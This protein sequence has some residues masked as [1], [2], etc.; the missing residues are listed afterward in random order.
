VT[1]LLRA[2]RER[3]AREDGHTLPE[4]L[5]AMGILSIVMT[6]LIAVYVQATNAEL[7][8]N[9]RF[10]AQVDAR[11]ALDRIRRDVHCASGISPAG[12]STGTIVV[13]LPSQCRGGGGNV[14]WCTRSSGQAWTLVRVSGSACNAGTTYARAVTTQN[15]FLFTAQTTQSLAKLRVELP[16]NVDRTKTYKEYRLLDEIVLRNSTR[17]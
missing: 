13:T 12:V 15:V 9:K 4:L 3:V 16:V 10:Q 8:M 17:S 6:G 5:T 14:T 7:D 1:Q 11:T 2:L